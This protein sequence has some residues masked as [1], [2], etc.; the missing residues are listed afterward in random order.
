M[1]A[2]SI[3]RHLRKENVLLT[4]AIAATSD[5]IFPINILCVG[6]AELK[7]AMSTNRTASMMTDGDY[8][9]VSVKCKIRVLRLRKKTRAG[10]E[11][12]NIWKG[13]FPNR[14]SRASQQNGTQSLWGSCQIEDIKRVE[15][16]EDLG[17]YFSVL[18][19]FTKKNWAS[20]L[21]KDVQG[22]FCKL[23]EL[24][25]ST[26]FLYFWRIR[27]LCFLLLLARFFTVLRCGLGRYLF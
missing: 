14:N 21:E 2:L 20:H 24:A 15:L 11:L 3:H 16:S 5:V 19:S 23:S 10:R 26:S 6:R 12:R 25:T 7:Y 9:T 8:M 22:H 4:K 13:L 1:V 18:V 17:S 27:I